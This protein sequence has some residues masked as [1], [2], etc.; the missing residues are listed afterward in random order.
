[1]IKF[2]TG[3]LVGPGAF[4]TNF[5][6]HIHNFV[7]TWTIEDKFMLKYSPSQVDQPGFNLF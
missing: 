3:S 5:S 6:S 2:H 1:M 4:D 7:M